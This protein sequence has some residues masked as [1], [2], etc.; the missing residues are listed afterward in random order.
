[1]LS[2]RETSC[3]YLYVNHPETATALA[4]ARKFRRRIADNV[5]DG[6]PGAKAGRRQR[7]TGSEWE[8]GRP[9]KGNSGAERGGWPGSRISCV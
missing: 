8:P 3:G 5:G 1:M 4:K 2:E 9:L 7:Y 6:T